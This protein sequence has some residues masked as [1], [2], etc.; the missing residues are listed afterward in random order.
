MV[1]DVLKCVNSFC[2]LGIRLSVWWCKSVM[3]STVCHEG[4]TVIVC[5]CLFFFSPRFCHIFRAHYLLF[6]ARVM[7]THSRCV[8]HGKCR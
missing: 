2:F 5:V 4:G 3:V 6:E 7:P 1:L 8:P